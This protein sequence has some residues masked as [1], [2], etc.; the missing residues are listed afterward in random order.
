MHEYDL[1]PASS[2]R[3]GECE[4]CYQMK[5]GAWYVDDREGGSQWFYCRPCADRIRQSRGLTADERADGRRESC[6]A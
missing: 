3:P 6:E 4:R 1:Y 2:E 5:L